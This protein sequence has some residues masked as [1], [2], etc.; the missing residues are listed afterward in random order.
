ML[1][2]LSEQAT[3]NNPSARPDNGSAYGSFLTCPKLC[4]YPPSRL[5]L[6]SFLW[7]FFP[8]AVRAPQM[9]TPDEHA[10]KALLIGLQ[11]VTLN[12]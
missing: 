10:R 1:A 6:S 2:L 11:H 12:M 5:G 3:M 9:S 4:I 7:P 8:V